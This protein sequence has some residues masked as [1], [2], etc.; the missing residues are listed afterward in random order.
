MKRKRKR[1][2]SMRRMTT[3]MISDL[4]MGKKRMTIGCY[5]DHDSDGYYL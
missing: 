2:I 3:A 1:I 5:R 4:R